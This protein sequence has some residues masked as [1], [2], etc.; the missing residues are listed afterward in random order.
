M[1]LL[2]SF[3]TFW[4]INSN[5]TSRQSID[6]IYYFFNAMKLTSD[7]DLHSF[8]AKDIESF[9]YL[10]CSLEQGKK[11]KS[12]YVNIPDYNALVN[13]EKKFAVIIKFDDKR[14]RIS[15]INRSRFFEHFHLHKAEVKTC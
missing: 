6:W 5:G 15:P 1:D 12:V 14:I 7:T 4:T 3:N 13:Q 11:K 10:V 8:S 9:R 2:N